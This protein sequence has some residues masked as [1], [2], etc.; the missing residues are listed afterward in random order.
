MDTGLSS[1]NGEHKP[2][3]SGKYVA[4][5]VAFVLSL[6]LRALYSAFAALSVPHLL[7]LPALIRANLFTENVMTPANRLAYSLFGVWQRFDTLNYVHIAQFG[8]DAPILVV[9][10]PLY[11]L[12]IRVLTPLF[13]DSLVTALAISFV[14]TFFL[15]WGLLLLVRL[16]FGDRVATRAVI[17]YAVWPAS[18]IFFCGYAESLVLA[19]TVWSIYFARTGRWWLAGILGGLAPLAKAVGML[20]VPALAILAIR[21][22]RWRNLWAALPLAGSAAY[23]LWLHSM[24]LSM[25][26]D[27]YR[28]YWHTQ[29]SWPWTVVS[30]T[31]HN[32]FHLLDMSRA[33]TISE[34]A[35]A[36]GAALLY[37]IELGWATTVVVL[38]LSGKLSMEL[39][40]YTLAA[41]YT[42][43]SKDSPV[44]QQQWTRYVLVLFPAAAIFALREKDRLLFVG[45]TMLCFTAN[46]LLMWLFLQWVLVV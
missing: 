12:L 23:P 2:L 28:L 5:T 9:F 32:V 35:A 30:H 41:L 4:P 39:L 31:V 26:W 8:Y 36:I 20:V 42:I 10:Y 37:V 34:F 19:L 14:A 24:G 6:V 13:K 38:A 27:A 1:L 21:E 16:D 22:R 44:V 33:G 43:F 45:A 29:T 11:P 15:F 40:V 25:P 46:L 3:G 17:F 18:F 7:L